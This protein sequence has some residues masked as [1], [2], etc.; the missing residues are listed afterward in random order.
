ME[1]IEQNALITYSENLNYLE[2]HHKELY[3]R[4]QLL[5]SAIEQNIYDE[6]YNLEYIK[7]EN[8]FDIYDNRTETFIYN[9]KPISFIRDA[10]K[11]TNLDKLN[12]MDLLN[13][14]V[15]N[16]KHSTL[17]TS[18]MSPLIKAVSIRDNKVFDYI[19]IFNKSTILE[20]KKFKYIS[21][22]IFIGLLLGTHV[23]PIIDKLKLNYCLIYEYNLEIFRLS[24]FA[25]NFE[26]LSRKCTLNFSIMED[27]VLT[28]KQIYNFMN[29]SN[30]QNYMIKYYSTNYNIHDYFDKILSISSQVNPLAFGFSRILYTMMTPSFK[31][32]Q[33]YPVLNTT[34]NHSL[35]NNTPVLYIAAG[36]S[37]GKNIKWIKENK[38]KFFIVAIGAVLKNLIK[39]NIKPDLIIT[40][41]SDEI[42]FEQFPQSIHQS[43][44]NIPI[45]ASTMTS[46]LILNIFNTK[47]I[48][49]FEVSAAFKT[50]SI[51]LDGFSIG[52][53]GLRL[54][55]ILGANN[56]YLIGTDMAFDQETGQTHTVGSKI[57]D[58]VDYGNLNDINKFNSF[59]DNNNYN[60][61]HSTIK[62][63]GNFQDYV[64]TNMQM[65]NSIK[66]FN[67]NIHQLQNK[68]KD[69]EIYNLN[70][71]AY[72]EGTIPTKIETIN[73]LF[74]K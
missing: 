47:N 54:I 9:K 73:T 45:L 35:L 33:E 74:I 56:I 10:I 30:N 68:N 43:I 70:E 59:T 50:T 27:D 18:E 34:F 3:D 21:K 52:E 25:T 61:L 48:F 17:I 14:S 63:K 15:Y 39:E 66:S 28:E 26:E 42:T 22:F 11:N 40:I 72:F 37:F 8:Q 32:I 4:I 38:N 41:D 60:I 31:N 58:D 12:T 36:P 23:K 19:K 69:V 57:D 55:S 53:I 24:L 64:I 7:E 5:S 2:S 1:Q 49:L 6:R 62:V 51:Q 44:N 71:G 29:A 20:N 46:K 67:R 65:A 13:P 16:L